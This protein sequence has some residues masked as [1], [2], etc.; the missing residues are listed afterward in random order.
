MHR[1]KKFL[2]GFRLQPG[3]HPNSSPPRK[4]WIELR[5]FRKVFM[6]NDSSNRSRYPFS[7]YPRG[8]YC[9][10]TSEDLGPG[11]VKPVHALG[12]HLTLFRTLSGKAAVLD[13]YCPHQGAHLGYGGEVDGEALCCP[14]HG[15]KFGDSGMCVSK[16]SDDEIFDENKAGRWSVCEVDRKI[17][18]FQSEQGS[19]PDFTI[20]PVPEYTRP[21][22]TLL[23]THLWTFRSHVQEVAE[24]L[25]DASHFK[26]LH[27]T[28]YPQT[29]FNP[30]GVIARMFSRLEL[31][32]GKGKVPAT[33]RSTGYGMSYWILEYT[34]IV[35][36]MV[37][38]TITPKFEEELD[39]RFEFLVR[40]D[41][42]LGRRFTDSIIREVDADVVIWKNKI[43]KEN[44]QIGPHDGPI[45]EYRNWCKQFY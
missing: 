42:K 27:K 33:L 41:L 11:E 26:V 29:E 20:P 23:Q 1:S 45:R 32:T 14:Y 17:F 7:H 8:W 19:E 15:W 40:G 13:A 44:P 22:W 4:E 21:E 12:T 38:A 36:T 30:E 28:S 43:Y 25:V 2:R 35:D 34:G 10:A 9:I 3:L 18:I 37:I 5:L 16:P 24:N 31:Y 6:Q 39:F